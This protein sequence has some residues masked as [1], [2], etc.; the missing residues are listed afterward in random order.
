MH[1]GEFSGKNA[2]NILIL[3]ESHHISTTNEADM[4]AGVKASYSTEEVIY[5]YFK[6]RNNKDYFF[7]D[8]IV[9]S[10]GFL[11]EEREKF[12]NSVYFGNYVDVLCG[13]GD[14]FA[15]RIIKENREKYNNELFTFINEH[16]ISTVFCFSVNVYSN[17]LPSLNKN[18]DEAEEKHIAGILNKKNVYVRHCFYRAGIEHGGADVILRKD[19]EI[20]GIPHPS[21]RGG[22]SSELIG[23]VLVG[24]L[25]KE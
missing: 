20:Y 22:Y 5:D 16:N 3:G 8:K 6:D 11:P 9:Q 15:K 2:G 17:G 13:V 18:S 7:F 10:F 23:S 19:L 4:T 24:K 1:Y 14:S 25:P 21:S 12:W